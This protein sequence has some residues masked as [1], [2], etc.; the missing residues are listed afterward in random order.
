MAGVAF[1][2]TLIARTQ[3]FFK[4]KKTVTMGEPLWLSGKV[5]V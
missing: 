4:Y 3:V 5:M 1:A 2:A